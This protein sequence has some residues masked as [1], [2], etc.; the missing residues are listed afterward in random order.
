MITG[1]QVQA[2]TVVTALCTVPPGPCMVV[3][4]SL[5]PGTAFI[6]AGSGVTA[7]NGLPLPPL[8][9]VPVV[10]YQ[11]SGPGTLSVICSAGGSASVGWMISR[12]SG[13]TG[14]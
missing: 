3:V 8:V 12:P 13:G 4:T 6:G 7:S 2:G 1:S 10:G 11:G 14:F 5:G 9:P